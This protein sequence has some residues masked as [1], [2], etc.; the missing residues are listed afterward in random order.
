VLPKSVSLLLLTIYIK[1]RISCKRQA[2]SASE[3]DA[4]AVVA[5]DRILQNSVTNNLVWQL[6]LEPGEKRE[7]NFAYTVTWPGDKEIVE[8]G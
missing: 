2:G 3:A 1:K 5:M 7:L 6:K 4:A 8:H